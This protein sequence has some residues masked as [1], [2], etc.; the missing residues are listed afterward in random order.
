[1]YEIET[2]IFIISPLPVIVL[3]LLLSFYINK[4]LKNVKKNE[5]LAWTL[6]FIHPSASKALRILTI[7][8]L[9]FSLTW[10]LRFITDF[11]FIRIPLLGAITTYLTLIG[12]IYFFRTLAKITE[13]K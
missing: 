6:I 2:I 12:L 10:A 5:K 1:M 9:I 4:F 7:I 13:G 3:F 8:C 11:L